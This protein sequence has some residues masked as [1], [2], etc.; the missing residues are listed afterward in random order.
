MLELKNVTLISVDG[1][2]PERTVK[3]LEYSS[4]G[5]NFG[6]IKLLSFRS[7]ENN[8]EKITFIPIR[9]LNSDG[10][11]RF[12]AKEL[13]NHLDTDFCIIVQPDGFL[14]N[15]HLWTDEYL[16]YDYIGAPW[17]IDLVD[18]VLVK[19]YKKNPIGMPLVGN[20]GFSLRSKK[21]LKEASI[22]SWPG[23]PE[24]NFF[25]FDHK[26]ALEK[27]GIKYAP[28]DVGSKFSME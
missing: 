22:F 15:P 27:I 8:L 7:P 3:A 4:R 6:S 13:Y 26:E 12:I 19:K 11:N 2:N 9:K 17:P 25:C 16:K 24:D 10:Y 1:V 18:A 5:I 21:I 14:L 20:G 23:G 28:V